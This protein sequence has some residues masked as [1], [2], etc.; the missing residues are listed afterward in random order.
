[1]QKRTTERS[2]LQLEL[3]ESEKEYI[4]SLSKEC[5]VRSAEFVRLVLF[6][7]GILPH[8]KQS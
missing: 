1:M 4:E 5:G 3:N 8:I 2:T 6:D 7:S